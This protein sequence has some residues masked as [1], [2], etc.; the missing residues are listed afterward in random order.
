MV[1]NWPRSVVCAGPAKLLSLDYRKQ[2][3]IVDEILDIANMCYFIQEL[4]IIKY[5][6]KEY[7]VHR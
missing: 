6:Y 2:K 7:D 3:V 4:Q 1:V 5:R